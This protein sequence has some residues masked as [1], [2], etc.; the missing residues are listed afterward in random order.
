MIYGGMDARRS[1]LGR[2][3]VD[4]N[5]V[6]GL[7]GNESRLGRYRTGT[8]VAIGDADVRTRLAL[9]ARVTSLK[10]GSGSRSD[11]G[12]VAVGIGSN[13]REDHGYQQACGNAQSRGK[14]PTRSPSPAVV[15]PGT[16]AWPPRPATHPGERRRIRGQSSSPVR[17][18]GISESPG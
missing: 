6:L 11:G 16:I 13:V 8:A 15:H 3:Q 9:A 7:V 2:G 5:E 14:A 18:I 17:L 10:H 12:G 1:V 4:G